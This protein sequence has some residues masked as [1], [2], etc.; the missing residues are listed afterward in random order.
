MMGDDSVHRPA[1]VMQRRCVRRYVDENYPFYSGARFGLPDVPLC[2]A[3]ALV[4]AC[5]AM[6]RMP[7]E[8]RGRLHQ[9]SLSREDK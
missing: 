7:P 8:V 4:R 6:V 5:N 3:I 9:G 1:S 2:V